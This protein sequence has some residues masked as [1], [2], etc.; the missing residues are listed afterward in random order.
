[1]VSQLLLVFCVLL[2]TAPAAEAATYSTI[3]PAT[4]NPIS[5]GGR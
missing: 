1:M 5:E 3:F 4:E 2:A